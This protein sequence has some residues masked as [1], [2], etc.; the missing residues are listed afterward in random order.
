[1]TKNPSAYQENPAFQSPVGENRHSET[2]QANAA[3]VKICRVFNLHAYVE[4]TFLTI[5]CGLP[6]LYNCT[7]RRKKMSKTFNSETFKKTFDAYIRKWHISEAILWI[8]AF[9]PFLAYGIAKYL[10]HV[11]I[12]IT[13][14][15]RVWHSWGPILGDITF[16]A[17]A[18][19]IVSIGA[20]F[21]WS[22]FDWSC[23]FWCHCYWQRI[24]RDRRDRCNIRRGFC[25]WKFLCCWTH[26]HFYRFNWDNPPGRRQ[27]FWD[28]SDRSVC[29]WIIRAFL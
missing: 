15:L 10:E 9:L 14:F 20:V 19:G 22:C 25:F 27:C 29:P 26:R 1:M 4:L 24:L 13:P 12:E 8:L 6:E 3:R 28:Y 21:F 17:I 16:G 23:F 18:S 11:K 7:N 2:Q 5:L